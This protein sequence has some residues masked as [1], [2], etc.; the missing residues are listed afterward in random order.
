MI[1]AKGTIL[2]DEQLPQVLGQLEEDLIAVRAQAPLSPRVVIDAC[3][4]LLE[5]LDRGELDWD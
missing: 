4:R 1:F 5:R 3:Q 2:P